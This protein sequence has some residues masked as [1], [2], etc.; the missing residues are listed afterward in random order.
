MFQSWRTAQHF[1]LWTVALV[2]SYEQFFSPSGLSRY[3]SQ[4]C[5]FHCPYL[6]VLAGHQ[7]CAVILFWLVCYRFKVCMLCCFSFMWMLFQKVVPCIFIFITPAIQVGR[8]FSTQDC[9]TEESLSFMCIDHLL[10]ELCTKCL[11]FF[12]ALYSGLLVCMRMYWHTHA[13]VAVGRACV[14]A[15]LELFQLWHGCFVVLFFT[16]VCFCN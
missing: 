13:A 9:D 14:T 1:H 2:D 12:L 5:L 16:V 4:Y 15:V 11:L 10:S 3:T 7:C 6:W 8:D